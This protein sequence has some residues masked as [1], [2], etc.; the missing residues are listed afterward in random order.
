MNYIDSFLQNQY[1]ISLS[2]F[3]A[4]IVVA[5][6]FDVALI[7]YAKKVTRNTKSD[8]SENIINIIEKPVYILILFVG[9]YLSLSHLPL[10]NDYQFNIDRIFFV[11]IVFLVT[12]IISRTSRAIIGHWL[13]AQ[14]KYR[15]TPQLITKILSASLYIIALLIILGHFRVNITPI[16]AT[17][18]V[19]SIAIGLALQSTLANFFAGLSIVSDRPVSVGDFIEVEGIVGGNNIAGTV[20]DIG[21]RSTRIRTQPDTIIVMPNNK[22]AESTIANT[23]KPRLET[24]VMVECGV[25]Y[26]SDLEK[27]EKVT[28][29]VGGTIQKN[30]PEAV[31]SFEPKIRFHTFADSN[32]NFTVVLRVKRYQDRFTLKSEFIKS[33]KSRY[34]KEGIEISWPVRKVYNER[35]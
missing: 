5:T 13:H 4:A 28:K 24:S 10:L 33:L 9:L 20:E 27:V 2:T 11:V 1:F 16:L 8:L 6:V 23:S 25:S 35:T 30:L 19:G 29:D 3:F 32:I 18:G 12:F 14:E 15:K 7:R 17:L 21:W 34:D 26:N 31:D 22:L